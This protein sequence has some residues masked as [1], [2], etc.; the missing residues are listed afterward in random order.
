VKTHILIFIFIASIVILIIGLVGWEFFKDNRDYP[1]VKVGE[2]FYGGI[3][4]HWVKLPNNYA[5]EV[6]YGE[7]KT[8]YK[9][10]SYEDIL[11]DATK[12]IENME[13]YFCIDDIVLFKAIDKN[14]ETTYW[15][16]DT[17]GTVGENLTKYSS[18]T[19]LLEAY[20]MDKINW[21]TKM[22]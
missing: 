4:G 9:I 11:G 18:E 14:N 22:Y 13:C 7:S 15:A 8:V 12:I 19:E 1:N 21:V 10:K 16:L 5:I 3:D 20:K 6:L 17:A 2:A